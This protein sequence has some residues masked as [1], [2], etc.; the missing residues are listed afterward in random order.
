MRPLI[1][2]LNGERDRVPGLAAMLAVFLGGLVVGLGFSSHLGAQ[3][4]AGLII[5]SVLCAV[6]ALLQR[7]AANVRRRLTA[8]EASYR[9]FFDHAVDGI[10]RTTPDGRYLAA[11]QALCDIYGYANSDE[12]ILGFTDIGAQLYIHPGR[13]EEFR[14]L[15]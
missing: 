2:P 8:G 7:V 6:L 3:F 1:D 11:N 12:L 4:T 5:L 14:A 10:F 13:R 9:A 15:I